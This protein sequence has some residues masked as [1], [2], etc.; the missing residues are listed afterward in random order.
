MP[1]RLK[2]I[3]GY[4]SVILSAFSFSASV[5]LVRQLSL[6][7][8][9]PA[10]EI[11]FFRF[12]IGFVVI[13]L[14]KTISGKNIKPV[15]LNNVLTRAF[16]NMIAVMIFFAIIMIMPATKANLYNMTYPV[17][18]AIIAHFWINE[19]LSIKAIISLVISFIGIIL[20][21]DIKKAGGFE[22]NDLWGI[23][24]G[25]TAGF[26]ITSLR[27]ARQTDESFTILFY[28]MLTGCIVTSLL[29]P[30]MYVKP[31]SQQLTLLI[32][33]AIF[34]LLGQF[35]ITYGYKFISAV[36]GAIAS[37]TR[38]FIVAIMSAIMLHEKL[39]LPLII[40]GLL[41]FISIVIINLPS[42]KK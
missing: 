20:I 38:I 26:A 14:I 25:V 6:S 24:S 13:Y 34:A 40:G 4:S 32:L 36:A 28:L 33:I 31:D 15:N 23:V 5:I 7:S 35:F 11:V 42:Q 39:T 41:I 22:L 12:L 37:S 19:K 16:S 29:M 21:A 1:E 2:K 3:L 30:T 9:I 17:F 8:D 10:M 27:R 18:V